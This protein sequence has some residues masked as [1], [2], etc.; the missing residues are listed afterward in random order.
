[1]SYSTYAP[2]FKVP[3]GFPELLA[4]L[5]TE[6]LRE[7]PEVATGIYKFAYTFFLKKQQAIAAKAEVPPAGD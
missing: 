3:E 7:Q 1:M 2:T 4:E 6:V 5:T